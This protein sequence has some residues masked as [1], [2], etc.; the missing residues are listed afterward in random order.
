MK[1]TD[2]AG[3]TWKIKNYFILNYETDEIIDGPFKATTR[4][5][6]NKIAR[7]EGRIPHLIGYKMAELDK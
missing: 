1:K 4:R 3:R 6:A 2:R 7:Q 5:G